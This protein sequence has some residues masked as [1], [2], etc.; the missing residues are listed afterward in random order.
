MPRVSDAYRRARRDEIA[1]AALRCL[2]RN[3]VARTSIADIVAESGLSAGAIYSHFTNKA[4]LARYI[5]SEYLVVRLDALEAEASAGAIRTPR[6]LVALLLGVFA[7][8][9]LPAK[10]VLQFWAEATV[11]DDIRPTFLA[12]VSRL[13]SSLRTTLTPWSRS[14]GGDGVERRADAAAGAVMALAQ[15]YIANVALFGDRDPAE[16]IDA[17]GAVLVT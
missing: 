15:G 6:E 7:D 14:L 8:E 16:Y 2:E 3:G 10:V 5:A 9:G 13:R 11:D 12:T 1:V 17:V 4:E